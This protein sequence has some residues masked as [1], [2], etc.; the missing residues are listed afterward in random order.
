MI[1]HLKS[2][3]EPLSDDDDDDSDEEEEEEA[4]TAPRRQKAK[5][6]TII[7]A[8]CV[9]C[10]ILACNPFVGVQQ[11]VGVSRCHQKTY[12]RVHY[13]STNLP[14]SQTRNSF[15]EKVNKFLQTFLTRSGK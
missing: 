12:F 2:S 13:V 14:I 4:T 1:N 3:P 10:R 15:I 8:V 5:I 11:V 9:S 6:F 7:F